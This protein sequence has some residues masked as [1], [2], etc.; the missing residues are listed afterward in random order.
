VAREICE[1]GGRI[2]LAKWLAAK[3]QVVVLAFVNGQ[4]IPADRAALPVNDRSFLYGDGLFETIR[5]TN[6]Q[7]F[8]WREHLDRLRRGA[9]FLK[10]PVPDSEKQIEHATRHLL[11]Q[12][13]MPEGVVR[14]HL[15]RGASERGYALPRDPKPTLVIT[16][17]QSQHTEHSGL[18][19]I[20]STIRVLAGDPLSQYKTANRL[21]NILA[22]QQADLAGV[23]EALL[24]NNHD[25]I[26]EASA[27]NIFIVRGRDLITPPVSAGALAGTTRAFVLKIASDHNLT[28]TESPL[29][30]AD[31]NSADATFL[32]S[33]HWLVTPAVSIDHSTLQTAS[34]AIKSLRSACEQAAFG[35]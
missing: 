9:D 13:D 21:P 4:F 28:P 35:F 6:G 5:I 22:R 3:Y 27:A 16:A 33:S 34:P 11:A 19:L 10:I 1:D 7:P 15:S 26:A 29:T 17:H 30:I 25:Q 8:L 23:D 32:T 20:T 24:L 18:K 2:S 31:L 14:I 12:N